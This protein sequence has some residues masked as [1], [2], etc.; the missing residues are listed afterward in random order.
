MLIRYE[1]RQMLRTPLR[2]IALVLALAVMT[3]MMT[4]SAGLYLA[5]QSALQQVDA[6]YITIARDSAPSHTSYGTRK[7]YDLAYEQYLK[8]KE[9]FLLHKQELENVVMYTEHNMYAAY[10]PKITSTLTADGMIPIP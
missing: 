9:M 8:D 1:T 4:V 2:L 7:E 3:V 6:E 5:C 10:S